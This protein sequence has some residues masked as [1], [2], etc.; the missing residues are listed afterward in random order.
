M[1]SIELVLLHNETLPATESTNATLPPSTQTLRL[2]PLSSALVATA[3][4]DHSQRATLR[5]VD[6]N[7]DVP[8]LVVSVDLHSAKCLCTLISAYLAITATEPAKSK[9]TPLATGKQTS[10]T[11]GEGNVISTKS[12]MQRVLMS[13]PTLRTLFWLEEE[14][15]RKKKKTASTLK[16]GKKL[17][18]HFCL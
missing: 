5:G 10:T 7:L 11:E 14:E 13:D 2:I 15:N 17:L 3:K 12:V 8:N 16:Q 6:M 4:L 9:A 18:K 1:E